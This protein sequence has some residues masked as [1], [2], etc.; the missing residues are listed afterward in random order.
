MSQSWL[1][2][3]LPIASL[4]ALR[5][6][7][8]FMLIPVFT[9]YATGYAGATPLWIGIAFGAYGLSQG[10]CQIP[11]GY[12]SDKYGRKNI[13]LLGLVLFMLGSLLG[14]ISHSIYGLLIS[15]ILQGS[16]AIGSVLMATL[17]DSVPVEHRSKSMAIIGMTIASSF[18]LAIV[19]S[20]WLTAHYGLTGLF[21]LM[22]TMGL[23]GLLVVIYIVRFAEISTN[24]IETLSI[25]EVLK[26][27]V[28]MLLNGSIFVQHFVLTATFYAVPIMLHRFYLKH[29]LES[30]SY[31]YLPLIILSFVVMMP[32]MIWSEKKHKTRE[33]FCISLLVMAFVQ[34]GMMIFHGSWHVLFLWMLGYF[35]VFNYFEATLPSLLFLAA[36]KKAKGTATG[37][38]SSFQFL[39]IFFGGLCAGLIHQRSG[40]SGI[41]L[42][43]ALVIV[44]WSWFLQIK[45]GKD[46]NM[47]PS[48]SE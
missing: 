19:F 26:L 43:N 12:G 34:L 45:N 36:P 29:T 14:A 28:L 5:M 2:T 17:A 31:F 33:V 20:P 32:M 13:L 23:I 47:F 24:K 11:F 22:F 10:I 25:K 4:Y 39:G 1:K 9:V 41:F 21:Y 15:R 42:M 37:V 16:G 18:A 3:T 27:P 38:Y 30:T 8:L 44:S 7:G 35:I 46:G 40:L 6:L 48:L